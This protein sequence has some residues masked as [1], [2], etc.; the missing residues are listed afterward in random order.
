MCVFLLLL[1]PSKTGKSSNHRVTAT[2][3]FRY[4]ASSSYFFLLQQNFTFGKVKLNTVHFKTAADENANERQTPPGM[5]RTFAEPL[6]PPPFLCPPSMTPYSVGSA[7]TWKPAARRLALDVYVCFTRNLCQDRAF[8]ILHFPMI[9]IITYF[10][11][12]WGSEDQT[13]TLYLSRRSANR[14]CTRLHDLSSSLSLFVVVLRHHA[15]SES[16]SIHHPRHS[17][18][19]G[20]DEW[21]HLLWI[22]V[23]VN[24]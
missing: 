20:A 7:S 6:N 21:N 19:D 13:I 11:F 15:W 24:R 8:S 5:S 22:D 4:S 3:G 18:I 2:T 1:H 17:R 16:V 9:S 14:T 12:R 23:E 10:T